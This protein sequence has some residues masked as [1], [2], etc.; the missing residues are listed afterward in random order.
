M[1]SAAGTIEAVTPAGVQP[2]TGNPNDARGQ[3]NGAP[4]V[5]ARSPS[6]VERAVV[7]QPSAVEAGRASGQPPDRAAEPDEAAATVASAAQGGGPSAAQGD[8]PS[9]AQGGDRG[10]APTLKLHAGGRWLAHALP[11]AVWTGVLGAELWTDRA[12]AFE[13]SAIAST[14]GSSTLA[15]GHVRSRLIGGEVLAC[16]AL[17]VAGFT[18]QGCGGFIAAQCHARGRG[19]P[20]PFPPATLLWA[21]GTA[22]LGL[23]WAHREVVSLRLVIQAHLN[24]VRPE[25]RVERSTERLEAFWLGG[26][27]GLDLVVSFD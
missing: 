13:L 27:G 25:L 5:A 11:T 2:A 6:P 3:S 26:A 24:L 4:E 16:H 1:P 12:L 8:G 9:A 22:R 19:Y 15:D 23:L 14:I 21:A 7:P 10:D 20:L 18:A 17:E